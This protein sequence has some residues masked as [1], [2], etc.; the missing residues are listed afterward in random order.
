[1]TPRRRSF[2]SLIL[3]PLLLAALFGS[4]CGP[5]E[6]SPFPGSAATGN[7]D[8]HFFRGE[9]VWDTPQAADFTLTDQFGQ[10]FRLSDHR[11]R[12]VLI[13]FGYIQC[14]EVCPATL[15]TWS[16]VAKRLNDDRERVRFVFITVDPERDTPPRL[17]KHLAIFGSDFIG[18]TGTPEQL[19]SVYRAYKTAHEKVQFF[20]SAAGYLVEHSSH[21]FLVDPE[22]KLR[23]RYNYNTRS[24]DVFHD[25]QW[26]LEHSSRSD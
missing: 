3:G 10:P 23:L 4:H 20:E 1:V 24:A 22:G 17:A 2:G 11:G 15:S 12:L 25:L 7:A 14:P 18:L 26:L 21:T 5:G 16:K 19:G 9:R 13:F 8:Q 6:T